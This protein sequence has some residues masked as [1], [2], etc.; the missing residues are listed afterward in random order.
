MKASC[1][2]AP[3]TQ[4]KLQ[5]PQ[6][7]AKV[8]QNSLIWLERHSLLIPANYPKYTYTNTR[9]RQAYRDPKTEVGLARRVKISRTTLWR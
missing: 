3:T 2:N 7:K 5:A 4:L 1:L 8:I 9:D 6:Q